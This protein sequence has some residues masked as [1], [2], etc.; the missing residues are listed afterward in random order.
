MNLNIKSEDL[1]QLADKD[2]KDGYLERGHKL[3]ADIL[4]ENPT[5]GKAHNHL[6]WLHELKYQ[7]LQEAEVHYK[8]ALELSPDYLATYYNYAVLLSNQRRYDELGKLLETALEI[9]GINRS[10]IYNEYGIMLEALEEYD[11]AI[12][13]YEDAAKL[14]MDNKRLDGY[15][16]S[17]ERAKKKKDMFGRH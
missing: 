12:R 8:K 13:Y 5:F 9:P 10:T 11:Q 1:F 3:L 4:K 16:A 2:I 17:V 14:T 6:G 15:I 7:R